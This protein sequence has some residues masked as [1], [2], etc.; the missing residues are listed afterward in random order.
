MA[1][2]AKTKSF[3]ERVLANVNK[4]EATQ[5]KELVTEKVT[6][7]IIECNTQIA[8]IE[9]GS[10]PKAQAKLA[11]AK[12][13]LKKAK[14]KLTSTSLE[15]LDY[16]FDGLINTINERKEKVNVA[17]SAI[18]EIE[19]EIENEKEILAGFKTLLAELQS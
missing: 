10:I 7:F 2:K 13:E 6:D 5:K 16:D 19:A 11:K 17:E 9:T 1:P 14:A 8:F 18:S 12:N 4:D 15:I 3:A